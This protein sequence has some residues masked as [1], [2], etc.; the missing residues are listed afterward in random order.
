[1]SLVIETHIQCDDCGNTFGVDF[2]SLTG[3]NQRKKALKNG[4]KYSGGKDYC[5]NCITKK[6]PRRSFDDDGFKLKY[7]QFISTVCL[8]SKVLTNDQFTVLWPGNKINGKKVLRRGHAQKN[9][10]SVG[11]NRYLYYLD[12]NERPFK[13]IKSL[14]DQFK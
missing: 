1:M 7:D 9:G 14:I 6:N 4:W 12:G 5:P 10:T 11:R 2:R 8:N 3:Y 13:T